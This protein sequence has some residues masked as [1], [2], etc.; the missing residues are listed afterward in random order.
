MADAT[1][2]LPR[3]I[4]VASSMTPNEMRALKQE[5][6]RPLSDLLGGDPEDMDLAP[7]R[8]QSLVWVALRRDGHHVSWEDA[9]D[10]LPDMTEVTPDPTNT[11]SSNSSFTSAAGGE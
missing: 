6:G 5:T 4:R 9:G 7:D 10:V 11:A 1:L 2:A 3:S 8:I